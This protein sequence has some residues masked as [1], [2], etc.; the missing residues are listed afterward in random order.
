MCNRPSSR[1]G[2]LPSRVLQEYRAG[3]HCDGCACVECRNTE[4][5]AY[6]VASERDKILSKNPH[7]FQDKRVWSC[8]VCAASALLW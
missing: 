3:R 1:V 7:A 4:E 6:E 5:H 2:P 8:V